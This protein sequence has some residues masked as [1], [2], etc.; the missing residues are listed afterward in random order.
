LKADPHRMLSLFQV[1]KAMPIGEGGQA[2]GLSLSMN[3]G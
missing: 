2:A 1:W 3:F